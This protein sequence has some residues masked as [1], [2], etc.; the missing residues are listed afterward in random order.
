M[1][2]KLS[3]AV[4]FKVLLIIYRWSFSC[5][6]PKMM[7][8][9]GISTHLRG[10]FRL[11]V[12]II[13]RSLSLRTSLNNAISHAAE[14]A[15]FAHYGR[16]QQLLTTARKECLAERSLQCFSAWLWWSV[17]TRSWS[18]RTWRWWCLCLW[19]AGAC[20]EGFGRKSRSAVMAFRNA[21][22]DLLHNR[23]AVV[24]SVQNKH[25]HV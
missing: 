23:H 24:A 11:F 6:K 17:C 25:W 12:N 1:A 8:K 10:L 2:L 16:I 13:S 18:R 22:W 20:W 4:L 5:Q 3:N 7:Q 21:D 19:T 15:H 9:S 14:R